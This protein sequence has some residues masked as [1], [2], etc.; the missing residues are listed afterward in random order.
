[1]KRTQ[2]KTRVLIADDHVFLRM[3][4]ATLF[5]IDLGFLCA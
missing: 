5:G 1:M 3:G 2:D 4:L